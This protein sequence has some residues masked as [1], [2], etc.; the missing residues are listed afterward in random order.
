[1]LLFNVYISSLSPAITKSEL[2]L[3]ADNAVLVVA[4][5]TFRELTDALRHNFN[6]ITNWYISNKLTINV[7]KTKLMLSGSKTMLSSFSDYV[8]F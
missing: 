2:I 5:S 3:Y 1:M 4:A 8:F 6:Q 7:K